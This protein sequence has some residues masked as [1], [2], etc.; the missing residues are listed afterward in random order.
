MKPVSGQ[1]P[2]AEP[3]N[4]QTRCENMKVGYDCHDELLTL[5]LK[6]HYARLT[7]C[8]FRSMLFE[9]D[10]ELIVYSCWRHDDCLLTRDIVD[11]ERVEKGEK[12][13]DA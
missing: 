6:P 5:C 13:D 2:V 3:P 9:V 7:I 8:E 11:S 10:D 12:N 1:E 4:V